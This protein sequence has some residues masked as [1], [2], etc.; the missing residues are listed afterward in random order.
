MDISISHLK[1]ISTEKK[2]SKP[3]FSILQI[4]QF[5]AIE[6]LKV[7]SNIREASIFTEICIQENRFIRIAVAFF[8]VYFRKI[9]KEKFFFKS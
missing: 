7:T 1:K 6:D 9:G 8:W 2:K 5:K 3:E 4:R